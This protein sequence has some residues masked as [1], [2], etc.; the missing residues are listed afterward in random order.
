MF[1]V[2]RNDP[3]CQNDEKVVFTLVGTCGQFWQTGHI[4]KLELIDPCMQPTW[5]TVEYHEIQ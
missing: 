4:R 2:D 3:F 1:H 5:N